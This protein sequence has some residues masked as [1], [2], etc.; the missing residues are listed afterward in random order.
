MLLP[1]LRTIARKSRV[2]MGHC[3]VFG[4]LLRQALFNGLFATS[5]RKE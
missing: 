2:E 5:V 1:G 4:F 3:C